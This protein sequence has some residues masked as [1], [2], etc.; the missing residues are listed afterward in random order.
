MGGIIPKFE[1]GPVT[2][3][4][5]ESVKGGL[6]VEGRAAKKVGLAAAGSVKCLGVATTDAKPVSSS[7]GTDPFG[8]VTVTFDPI[9]QYTAVGGNG[10]IYPVEY[11]ADAAF[12]DPLICAANGKVT[13]AGAAPDAR[14]I[15]GQCREPGGVVVATKSVGLAKIYV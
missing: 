8:N 10:R 4:V 9:D 5:V 7:T 13:P 1:S 3:E 6:L 15:V 11:A 14:T 12:G 2:Y